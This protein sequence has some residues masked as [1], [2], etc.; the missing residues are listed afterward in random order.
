MGKTKKN[1]KEIAINYL[2][3][4][5]IPDL[6][7]T[8]MVPFSFLF[9][10]NHLNILLIAVVL[11]KLNNNLKKFEKFEY[12]YITKSEREQ[13]YGLVKV[14]ILNFAIGHKLSILLNLM[15]GLSPE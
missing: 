12:L 3:N 11:V 13:Y 5:F 10:S 14:F 4:E 7:S 2:S 15:A 8:F 6:I 1:L 9:Q